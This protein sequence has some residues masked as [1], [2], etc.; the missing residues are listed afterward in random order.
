MV[1]VVNKRLL[2]VLIITFDVK[3]WLGSGFIRN[4]KL[5][6]VNKMNL[7]PLLVKKKNIRGCVYGEYNPTIIVSD[8]IP[9]YK[10]NY[11]TYQVKFVRQ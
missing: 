1:V 8:H 2:S 3:F 4:K 11:I 6:S 7:D 9:L 5:G 10:K